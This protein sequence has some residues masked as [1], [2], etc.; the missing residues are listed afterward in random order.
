MEPFEKRDGDMVQSLKT[1][2]DTDYGKWS[3]IRG[4]LRL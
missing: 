2:R 4:D 3:E 1:G